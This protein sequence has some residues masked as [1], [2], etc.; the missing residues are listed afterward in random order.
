MKYKAANISGIREIAFIEKNLEFNPSEVIIKHLASAP[1]IG[2]FLHLYR[3]EHKMLE[4][5]WMPEYPITIGGNGVGEVVEVGKDVSSVKVGDLV[6]TAGISDFSVSD[7]STLTPIPSGLDI[8]EACFLF[9][10]AIALQSVR[11]AQIYLGANPDWRRHGGH[12]YQ[13]SQQ[14]GR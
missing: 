11:R 10:A 8:E 5:G 6:A 1:S 7:A 12:K 14:A 3:G 13:P 4:R 2:T 9:Q